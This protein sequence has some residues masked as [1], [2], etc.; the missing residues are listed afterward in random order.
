MRRVAVDRVRTAMMGGKTK[1]DT[2]GK[3]AVRGVSNMLDVK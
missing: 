3:R 2:D 1:G